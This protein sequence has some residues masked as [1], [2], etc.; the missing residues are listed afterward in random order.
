MSRYKPTC[1]QCSHTLISTLRATL[2]K[3]FCFH[4]YEAKKL[5]NK[6][7]VLVD[8]SGFEPI[9]RAMAKHK[10]HKCFK[11]KFKAVKLYNVIISKKAVVSYSFEEDGD[12]V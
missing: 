5:K 1:I 4:H 6:A 9:Y 8:H 10:C 3:I 2:S 12:A 11:T 7:D